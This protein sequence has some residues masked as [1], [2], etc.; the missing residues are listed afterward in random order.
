MPTF[1]ENG[2]LSREFLLSRGYCC[3][4]GC[5]NC[6]YGYRQGEPSPLRVPSGH[7]AHL[8][9]GLPERIV[10]LCPSNTELVHAL[11]LS[12]RLVGIDDWSD[13]PPEVH[14]LPRVGPDL[15]IDMERV[16]A[17]KPE[18]VVAS[19]T[20]PGMEKNLAALE[21]RRLPYVV[22]APHSLGDIW[23]DLRIL[24][25]L[26]GTEARAEATIAGLQERI[27]RVRRAAETRAYRPRVYWEWWPR[28]LFCPGKQNW[29]TPISELAGCRSVTA[30]VDAA[31]ARPS[32]QEIAAADPEYIFLA[33]TGVATHKVRPEVLL[34]RPGWER[35]SAVRHGRVHVM[36]EGLYCR[37][38]PRL[39]DG[40]EHLM[41]LLDSTCQGL[42][43]PASIV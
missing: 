38:S 19:L 24:G 25:R 6:P 2:A 10:S 23:M 32:P 20:V 4:N 14:G 33:W 22:F 9:P 8:R 35:I 17:L 28:P 11:G 7:T 31:A 40:L 42:Q 3:E 18:L 36:E 27:Q 41:V 43:A 13:W 39:I 15:S 37:P 34:R 30:H 29:L 16:E 5:R 12:E 1:D 26:T 21:A